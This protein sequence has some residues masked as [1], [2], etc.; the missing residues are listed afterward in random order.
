MF[1]QFCGYNA[2]SNTTWN[3]AMGWIGFINW[4]IGPRGEALWFKEKVSNPGD[5]CHKTE[6]YFILESTGKLCMETG[7]WHVREHF[8]QSVVVMYILDI[9]VWDSLTIM[10]VLW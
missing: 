7:K 10:L 6:I 1:C 5:R 9:I 3:Y 4:H 8:R 2:C